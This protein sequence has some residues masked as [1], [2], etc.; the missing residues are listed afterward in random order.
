MRTILVTLILLAVW[1]ATAAAGTIEEFQFDSPAVGDL[2]SVQVYLPD[3]YDPGLP[4]GYPAIYFLHGAVGDDHTGYPMLL[5]I[6]DAEIA[7]GRIQP[8]V[9]VKPDGS[10]CQWYFYTGC[11][12]S[13]SE[14][15]GDFE[16]FAVFEVVAEA[17]DRYNISPLPH[18]RA[19][20]GHSMAPSG[21]C[22]PRWITPSGTTPWPPTVATCTSTTFPSTTS[23][24]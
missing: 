14:L 13:D 22:R 23:G 10:G 7:A 1:C 15:Q 5:D 21:P 19:I 20:M 3:S 17:E 18:R 2:R 24:A 12:W 9:I 4:G 11:G 6:A 8:T 16:E